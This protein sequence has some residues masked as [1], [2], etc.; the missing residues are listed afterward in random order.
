MSL[1]KYNYNTNYVI[2]NIYF[3]KHINIHKIKKKI[4]SILDIYNIKCLEDWNIIQIFN[5]DDKI[6]SYYIYTLNNPININRINRYIDYLFTYSKK[7]L[8]SSG[9]YNYKN[10]NESLQKNKHHICVI[11]NKNTSFKFICMHQNNICKYKCNN[12]FLS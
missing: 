11:Y 5:Q 4:L 3:I 1:I 12:I 7:F 9:C 6:L 8:I 2:I 10:F